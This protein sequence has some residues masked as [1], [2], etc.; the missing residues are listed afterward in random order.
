MA[1]R[2]PHAL[3]LSGLL[4]ALSTQ[5]CV[6]DS[7]S[8]LLSGP[9]IAEGQIE[10]Q[11]GMTSFTCEFEANEEAQTVAAGVIDLERLDRIGQF[12]F[13]STLVENYGTGSFVLAMGVQNRLGGSN[14]VDPTGL[15]SNTNDVLVDG[16]EISWRSAGGE[17]V[18]YNP[19]PTAG[20]GCGG[21]GFRSIST[22]VSSAG[23]A[24]IIY[25]PLLSSRVATDGGRG[26]ELG[27]LRGQ[28][29]A[30]FPGADL[31]V[32][33]QLVQVHIRA[34]GETLDGQNVES[35][36]YVFPISVCDGCESIAESLGDE[37]SATASGATPMCR[38]G[39]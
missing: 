22:K 30:A 18:I 24:R 28:L 9:Y 1:D 3:A 36:T 17:D 39:A 29:A 14:A 35:D 8:L 38:A 19:G 6:D 2:S 31:A 27:C 11:D 25:V 26:N 16:F 12:P 34:V 20:V 10:E 32:A 15:R 13:N 5:A 7:A 21:P 37:G 33:P 23:A 4:I